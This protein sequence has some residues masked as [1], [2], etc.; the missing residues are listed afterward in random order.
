MVNKM[1]KYL[2]LLVMLSVVGMLSG[3]LMAID[4]LDDGEGREVAPGAN[5]TGQ[6][7]DVQANLEGLPVEL[8]EKVVSFLPKNDVGQ[9]AQ[10]CRAAR[11]AV[12]RYRTLVVPTLLQQSLTLCAQEYIQIVDYS[13]GQKYRQLACRFFKAVN[14]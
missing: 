7:G 9:F 1:Y 4:P 12:N 8:I 10:T 3:S 11:T 6:A 2:N 5:I 14:Y 13:N